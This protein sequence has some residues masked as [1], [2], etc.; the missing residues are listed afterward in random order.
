MSAE[1]SRIRRGRRVRLALG[2]LI[3]SGV[4][5]GGLWA[6]SGFAFIPVGILGAAA[7]VAIGCLALRLWAEPG[8]DEENLFDGIELI[9]Q[10]RH[11]RETWE[12][13]LG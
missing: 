6:A 11:H 1:L 12:P 4:C 2:L 13:P 3:A 5:A 10:L 8:S 7:A 9:R